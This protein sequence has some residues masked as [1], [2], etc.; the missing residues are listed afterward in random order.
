MIVLLEGHKRSSDSF[1]DIFHL[2]GCSF[3]VGCREPLNEGSQCSTPGIGTDAQ[4]NIYE[5][6][7]S[8]STSSL[9]RPLV[10]SGSNRFSYP[11][12]A[13][14]SA[15]LV[16]CRETRPASHLFRFHSSLCAQS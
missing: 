2:M 9:R 1:V 11:F 16:S 6:S 5:L 14:T 10:A 13:Q 8:I 3:T 4:S 12:W 7:Y 15:L